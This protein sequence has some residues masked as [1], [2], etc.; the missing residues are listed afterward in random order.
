MRNSIFWWIFLGF[1]LSLDFYVF[2][3]LRV[4]DKFRRFQGKIDHSR[5]LL[6]HLRFGHYDVDHFTLFTFT[7]QNRV[8]RN[9]FSRSL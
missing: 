2:Q 9:T 3:A 7:Q 5:H 6:D 4:F 1:M 8:A